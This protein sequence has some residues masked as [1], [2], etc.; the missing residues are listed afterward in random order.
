MITT[1]LILTCVL[2]GICVVLWLGNHNLIKANRNM[3]QTIRT[4][5]RQL[6]RN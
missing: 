2:A 4:L 1:L 3:E 6:H 5:R